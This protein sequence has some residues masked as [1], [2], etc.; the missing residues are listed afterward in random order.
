MKPFRKSL[1]LILTLIFTVLSL[2]SCDR[3]N[4][5][6]GFRG[7]I[8]YAFG[9]D[10][11][12][13]KFFDKLTNRDENYNDNG[14]DDEGTDTDNGGDSSSEDDSQSNAP[15]NNENNGTY[16][17]ITIAE[18]LNLCGEPGNITSERYYIKATVKSVTNPSYGEMIVEDDTGEIYVYGTYSS[19]GELPFSALSE[20]P[21]KGDEVILHCILQNYEGTKEI[22]N[23][24]LIEFTKGKLDVN[25]AD[26]ADMTILNARAAAK[27]SKIKVDG[28]VARITYANGMIPSGF[29]LV[30]ETSSIYVYDGNAASQVSIGNTVTVLGEKD[31]WILES[32]QANASKF[33]YEGCLQLANAVLLSNDKSISDYNKNWI[34]ETSVKSIMETPFTENITTKLFKVNALITKSNDIGFTNYYINDIDGKTGSYVYTQCNGSDF[35]WLDKFDGKICTVYFTALNAKSGASGCIYRFLPVEVIDEGYT[36]N[37]EDAPEFALEYYALSQFK[38]VYT[39]DPAT[40]LITS[41]SS[42][43]LGF[44]NLE[45]SYHSDNTNTV[46]FETTNGKTVLH[47]KDRGTASI[48]ITA[49]LNKKS[50][51]QTIDISV[52]DSSEIDSISVT[53]AI[54]CE[55]NKET[56]IK[57][58]GIVGPSLINKVG[59][60]LFDQENMI[61]VLTTTEVMKELE[62]GYEVVIE[63][64]RDHFYKNTAEHHGQTCLNDASIVANYYGSHD[65][66]TSNF[67]TGKTPADFYSLDAMQDYS[68]TAFIL[69]GKVIFNDYGYYSNVQLVDSEEKTKVTIYCSK[70]DNYLWL[71]DY[72][73]QIATFEVA[74]CNWN[75]KNFYAGCILAVYTEN[76]KLINDVNF[77]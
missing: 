42:E 72:A 30:D 39:G 26:Y 77:R 31:Y 4:G 35:G 28:V 74:A 51:S 43:L 15:G 40:E 56:K 69:E 34:T 67:I 7:I 29:I 25:V 65:Y 49:T 20:K 13:V 8:S 16:K 53:D 50:A 21:T 57:V 73:N 41:L 37:I 24:R 11:A 10:N 18:A 60:Y 6:D 48:T 54:A 47:C 33:G 14:S 27:A 19:N 61:A 1:T 44:E 55:V 59:F 3:T 70:S 22:K 76:G 46:Y 36:F 17:L 32:E 52:S 71:K 45:I 58:W 12:I 23:A 66:S 63:A 64:T 38:T 75:G 68:T 9:E 2:V 5:S 62:I